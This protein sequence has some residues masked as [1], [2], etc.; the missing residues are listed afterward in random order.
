M[1]LK[2]IS[3]KKLFGVF[4]HKIEIN[5]KEG[6][7]IVIGENGLGKTIILEM[8]NA[9]YN[10]HFNYFR[11]V[12]FESF[13]LKY[14]DGTRWLVKK[15][16]NESDN[17]ILKLYVFKNRKSAPEEI[18]LLNDENYQTWGKLEKKIRDVDIDAINKEIL[19]KNLTNLYYHNIDFHDKVFI[20][21]HFKDVLDNIPEEINDKFESN[22]VYLIKTQRLISF[23]DNEKRKNNISNTVEEYSK[24]LSNTIQSHLAQ[25]TELSSAL[26]RTYPNRLLKRLKTGRAKISS[27]E[28][29]LELSKL[30]EKRSLLDR[31]GLIGFEKD[32]E[33]LRLDDS[34]SS[35]EVRKVLK[36]YVEDNFEKLKI[37]D[38]LAKKIETFL[39]II[40]KRFKHK[41]LIIDKD[42]GFVFQSTLKKSEIL[43]SKLSSGEQNE[44]VLFYELLFKSPQNS[45]ILIDEPEISLHISWQNTFIDDIKDV[46]ALNKLDVIIATHS[47]NIIGNNWDLKVELKGLE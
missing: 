42:N 26:D 17:F 31:V 35:E 4:D 11:N 13:E 1:K 20:S 33:I 27:E 41:Q 2:E 3:V 24:D 45:L 7:T 25:S 46:I 32:T 37:Y 40:N 28:L 39:N 44:L 16:T 36:L 9:F 34:T 15:E 19:Y 12:D 23:I 18:V 6:I 30:E 38:E 14:L 5:T 29:S 21:K 43:P 22:K 8:I 10:K 47:P